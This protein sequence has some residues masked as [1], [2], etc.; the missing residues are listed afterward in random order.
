MFQIDNVKSKFSFK[1]FFRNKRYLRED[2]INNPSRFREFGVV[3]F[4][5]ELGSGKPQ[6]T[7]C[8]S[9]NNRKSNPPN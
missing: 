4:C 1:N 5:G 2:Y 9:V 3:I 7:I 8:N 6:F